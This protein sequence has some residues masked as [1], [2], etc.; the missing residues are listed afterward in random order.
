M[1]N[2]LPGWVDLPIRNKYGTYSIVSLYFEMSGSTTSPL[3]YRS[4]LFED[5]LK[6]IREY[7]SKLWEDAISQFRPFPR[8]VPL[9][10]K[11]PHPYPRSVLKVPK[12]HAPYKGR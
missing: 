11:N 1:S 4:S 9:V 8:L 3:F 5:E 7:S 12:N 2:R 6:A 10:A